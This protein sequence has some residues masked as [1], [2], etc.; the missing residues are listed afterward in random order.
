MAS[1]GA[2]GAER[3][4][5]QVMGVIEKKFTDTE[6][7]IKALEKEL[8]QLKEARDAAAAS[9]SFSSQ[10][11]GLPLATTE[12]PKDLGIYSYSMPQVET[13]TA[14][15]LQQ[16]L[17]IA[18]ERLKQPAT[19]EDVLWITTKAAG[20]TVAQVNTAYQQVRHRLTVTEVH[21]HGLGVRMDW[22]EADTR[23]LQNR[24][25]EKQLVVK[26]WPQIPNVKD[27]A[28]D[29]H[30]VITHYLTRAGID[31]KDFHLTTIQYSDGT[32]GLTII[33]FSTVVLRNKALKESADI[34][35]VSEGGEVPEAKDTK[36]KVVPSIAGWLRRLQ[37]PLEGLMRTYSAAGV[38]VVKKGI[39][40]KPQ[41]KTLTIVDPQDSEAWMGQ[42]VYRACPKEESTT[43]FMCQILVPAE[44]EPLKLEEVFAKQWLDFKV[45]LYRATDAEQ[46]HAE[47]Q[48]AKESQVGEASPWAPCW[49]SQIFKFRPQPSKG[50]DYFHRY[51]WEFPWPIVFVRVPKDSP[52]RSKKD[53]PTTAEYA[54][55]MARAATEG[56][57]YEWTK[58]RFKVDES[59]EPV[60]P[61]EEED[62]HMFASS[63]D[64]AKGPKSKK[65]KVGS[66]DLADGVN[67]HTQAYFLPKGSENFV[68]ATVPAP[69]PP[70]ALGSGSGSSAD[71]PSERL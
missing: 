62:T 68:V 48:E 11:P 69:P 2:A 39:S 71:Q 53:S 49:R 67:V 65:P 6:D 32:V 31:P 42:V 30:R 35:Y 7:R 45:G 3:G 47:T 64:E 26:K 50:G 55:W 66:L 27:T 8:A 16:S 9:S 37:T 58:G 17:G 38:G 46:Q 57:G 33:E 20:P 28:D 56:W 34:R 51:A 21:I 41:W 15:G 1:A 18:P 24:V 10:M 60:K 22:L 12:L 43:G 63:G 40:F 23:A 13:P 29:K 61:T 52:I 4:E 36:I 14:A 25:A 5:A 54:E 70:T 19:I 59:T 44:L